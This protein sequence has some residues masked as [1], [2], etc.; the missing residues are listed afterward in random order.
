[1]TARKK[2][3]IGIQ[4]FRE[5][6]E[7]NYYYVDKT[8]LALSLIESGKHYFL[9]RPRRFGKSLFLDTLK[10]LFEGNELLFRGL[11]IHDQWDW[12]VQ[13]PVLR[14][15]FGRNNYNVH[16][17][18]KESLHQQLSYFERIL[19]MPPRLE[20]V[21]GRFADLI[22]RLT[23]Q[24]NLPLVILID[25]YDKPILDALENRELASANRDFLRGFYSTIKD[26]DAKIKFSLLTG[27]TKFSKVSL[28][29][30][31]NNLKD[32]T[33]DKRYS[34]LCGYTDQDIDTVF[35][36]ELEGLDRDSIRYWYNGYNWLGEGVYNPFDVLNL[37]DRR[38]FKNYWFETGTPTFLI[39]H[40][41]NNQFFTPNLEQLQSDEALLSAFD[42]DHI[43]N[44]ALLFQTGYLTIH[45]VEQPL[46][47][48]WFYT[49]GYPNHEVKSSLNS[50]LLSAYG[51]NE[52]LALRN[53]INLIKILQRNAVEELQ[54]LF[55]AFFASIPHQWYDSSRG[56]L[57]QYEG[58][59][60]SIF[61]SHFAAL[62]IDTIVEDSSSLGRL[63]MAVKFSGRIY[64]FEFK[65]LEHSSEGEALRQ[66]HDKRYADKYRA[67]NQP[68]YLIGVEFSKVTR[69]IVG[70]AIEQD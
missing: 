41:A 11:A 32:I 3:P 19:D 47:G 25:E 5:I 51:V 65:V 30:G 39:R 14:F 2:L 53:R 12:S 56:V 29:S 16:S 55:H 35:A 68:L 23:E 22:D 48:Y 33:L 61:Y 31:L 54:G 26:Y 24:T 69:N 6:R 44:E 60:A 36:P 70:F 9:S 49:L 46:L 20:D 66:I 10:E 4:T 8:A 13:Y 17:A 40:L 42:I 7:N 67:L 62:G 64:L 57:A 1:M 38:E 52:S 21:G 45:Q 58:Y 43:S 34:T 50:S 37:F 28:F 27:V 63:D 18:L 15:S 59:Y